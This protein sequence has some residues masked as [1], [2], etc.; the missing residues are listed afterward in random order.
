[1]ALCIQDFL[2]FDYFKSLEVLAGADGLTGAVDSCGILDYELEQG[3]NKKY[4]DQNFHSGQLV[5]T[6]LLFAKNNPFLVRDAVK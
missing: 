1:M 2:E 3:L 5:L 4:T 6:S